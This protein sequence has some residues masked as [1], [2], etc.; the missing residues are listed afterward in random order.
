MISYKRYLYDSVRFI[1]RSIILNEREKMKKSIK[2]MFIAML[3]LALCVQ[4]LPIN[5]V[6]LPSD[7]HNRDVSKKVEYQVNENEYF[8]YP[9]SFSELTDNSSN[10][11]NAL[12]GITYYQK[13]A[14]VNCKEHYF[15]DNI[16]YTEYKNGFWYSGIL[17][18]QDIVRTSEGWQAYYTGILFARG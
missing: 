14:S 8:Y 1:S 12:T 16:E 7:V 9:D 17:N 11:E 18:L 4:A 2:Q 15:F 5:A 6:E 13:T 3:T 10:I